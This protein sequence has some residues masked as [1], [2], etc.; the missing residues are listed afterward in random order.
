MQGLL[1]IV[2]ATG[3]FFGPVSGTFAKNICLEKGETQT[4][5]ECYIEAVSP[6]ESANHTRYN[7]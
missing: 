2:W 4:T 6:I 5:K 3:V 7:Q 1:L